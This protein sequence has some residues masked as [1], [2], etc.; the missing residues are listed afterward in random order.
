M[1]EN[2]DKLQYICTFNM[3]E[4]QST[5]NHTYL[6]KKVHMHLQ[7]LIWLACFNIIKPNQLWKYISK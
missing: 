1:L 2:K 4:F 3:Q 5:K 7:K 6:K